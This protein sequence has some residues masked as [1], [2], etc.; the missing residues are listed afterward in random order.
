MTLLR[1]ALIFELWTHSATGTYEIRTYFPVQTLR[2][3][4]YATPLT[5][6]AP[7]ERVPVFIPACSK[8]DFSYDWPSFSQALQRATDTH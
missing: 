4:R 2:Q 3:M 7:P 5:L 6:E 1:R 8:A